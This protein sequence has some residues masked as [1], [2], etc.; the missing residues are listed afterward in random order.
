MPR[1]NKCPKYRMSYSE[2]LKRSIISPDFAIWIMGPKHVGKESTISGIAKALNLKRKRC[3]SYADY[4]CFKAWVLSDFIP[5]PAGSREMPN[6]LFFKPRIY[7][8]KSDTNIY[9]AMNKEILNNELP[10]DRIITEYED[11]E[12]RLSYEIAFS[13]LGN[14]TPTII[15]IF[16]NTKYIVNEIV[17][18][19]MDFL[20]SKGYNNYLKVL[21]SHRL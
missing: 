8:F 10:T 18:G 17:A 19:Y 6:K 5:I 20:E 15:D 2:L 9:S 11:I 16:F 7:I 3:L 21:P 13:V 1:L 14:T 4:T 12:K